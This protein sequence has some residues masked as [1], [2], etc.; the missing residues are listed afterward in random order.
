MIEI[1]DKYRANEYWELSGLDAEE[2]P[3]PYP[4]LLHAHQWSKSTDYCVIC[5]ADGRA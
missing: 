5:G 1:E 4:E 2:C 3:P